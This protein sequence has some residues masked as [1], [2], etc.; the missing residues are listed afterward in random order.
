MRRFLLRRLGWF[1][2]T[3]FCVV[4]ISFLLMR[5]TPGGPFSFDRRLSPAV[6]QN[7][8][9]RYH[10]DWPLWRQYLQYVGPFNF[11]EQGVL[12]TREELFGGVL[13]GDLGPS[14]S[15]R[16]LTVNDVIAQSFPI[17]VALGTLALAWA[18]VLGLG[19]GIL[20]ALK[21]GSLVDHAVRIVATG[22][23]VLPNFV[24]AG[25]LVLVFAI[26]LNLFP[27]A[28]WGT[29][30]HMVLP[31]FALGAPFAAGI[32]RLSRTGILEA[33]TKPHVRTAVAKGLPPHLVLL[34]HALKE[35]VLPVVSYIG[36][37]AAGV[38]T[39]SLVIEK[40]F[41]IPGTGS[42]FVNGAL[43]RDYTL[44]MGVTLLYTVLVYSLNTAVDLA[45]SLLDPRIDL[46][47][48]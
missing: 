42:H 26:T 33:L 24:I 17:S 29:L 8:S 43:N 31:S 47:R 37:V 46:E 40:I 16:D 30:R 23:I 39:G 28:G 32:A 38:L 45:Y 2:I 4:T 21:P 35:G 36:P 22:G 13:T 41:F 11:D 6:E 48:S 9:A 10:L 15:H 5:T 12:G 7:I 14:F 3:V 27:V 44:A 20:S 1:A 34:R 25:L 18:L 19:A